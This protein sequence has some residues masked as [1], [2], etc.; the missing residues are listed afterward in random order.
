[1]SHADKA[2]LLVTGSTG[3]IG[4][5]IMAR[6]QAWNLETVAAPRT[7]FGPDCAGALATYLDQM[8]PAFAIDAAGVVPGRGD[9]ALNLALTRTWIEALGRVR[10]APRL[11]LVG[12]AAIYGTGAARDRATGEDDPWRPVS[13]YGRAK[14]AALELGRAAHARAGHDI[15]TAVVFN[16]LGAGQ[17]G[18]LAPRVFIEKAIAARGG[19]YEV[20]PVHAVRDFMDVEDAADALIAMARHGAAGEILNVATGRP[21]RIRD[22]LDTIGARIGASWISRA[23]ARDEAGCDICYGD[24]AR[25]VER[26]G[27]HPR[28]DFDTALTRAM[29]AVLVNQGAKAKT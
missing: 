8:Q 19:R 26:T 7:I 16:L 27:W 22:L 18:H 12:S 17:P 11:V 13:D 28:F 14:L 2:K 24:P 25:L 4:Q 1:M 3:F 15:Q 20:G 29:D 21:T 9:V 23:D 10:N 6:A 5:A